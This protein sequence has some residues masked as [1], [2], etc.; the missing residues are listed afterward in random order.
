MSNEIQAPH[1]ICVNR[2]F[3]ILL[4]DDV[5]NFLHPDLCSLFF[6]TFFFVKNFPSILLRTFITIIA[7]KENSSLNLNYFASALKRATLR[8][9]LC[10]KTCIHITTSNVFNQV[11]NV[12]NSIALSF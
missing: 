11:L 3:P 4:C 1:V 2:K 8:N 12:R 6:V 7:S 10:A 5:L 9:S